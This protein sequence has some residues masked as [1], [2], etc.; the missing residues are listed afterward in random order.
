MPARWSK[1]AR[2]R[3]VLE[4]PLPS[5]HDGPDAMPFPICMRDALR[6][7]ADRR[8]R[9][10]SC[11][12]RR[13]AAAS[14]RAVPSSLAAC[15]TNAA[16]DRR[17]RRPGPCLGLLARRR[18]PTCA[19]R[20]R[21]GSGDMG[22]ARR[23][24]R[25]REALPRRALLG[26]IV[27]GARPVVRAVRRRELRLGAGEARRHRRRIRLRQDHHRPPAAEAGRA[28]GRARS[29]STAR[30]L[31]GLAAQRCCDFR[32]QAQLVFQNPF[33]ALNPRFTIRR[34]LAEPLLNAGVARA[35][36]ATRIGAALAPRPAC[37]RSR[38]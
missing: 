1:A 10:R 2:S 20:S 22:C 11:S 33:D 19:R 18:G 13:P 17:R 27:R 12:I 16:A 5:L 14:R 35:E 38:R 6:A 4:R 31:A 29:P 30:T 34:A 24:T 25:R 32:R 37:R 36:H 8:Q 15:A 9:R 26:K 7:G 21:T 23:A 3:E 28:D